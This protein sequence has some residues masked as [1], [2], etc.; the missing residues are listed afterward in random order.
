MV[1]QLK[2]HEKKLLRKVDFYSYKSD[3]SHREHTIR[4]RYHLQNDVDYKK[5]NAL[6]GSLRQLAH[7]LSALD[8][9][10]DPLRKKVEAEVLEKLWRM[11]I[12]KQNRE[13]GAGLSRVE[14]EVTVSAFC[15]RRLAVL[16][17]RSGMVETIKAA[18]TFIEQGH[19]RVGTEVVTDPA[20]LVTRNMEDFV[21]WVDSSKI[22]RTI[23]R[24]RDKMDDFDLM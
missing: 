21:T 7:K 10:S 17:V 22:K 3:S 23:M 20:F 5:Y 16:M 4:Q 1:R 24:Y 14:R 2:H 18:V 19:V 13:Q 12:L 15:R 8:P 6:A 9:D 11:G